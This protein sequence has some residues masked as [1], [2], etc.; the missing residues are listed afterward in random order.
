MLVWITKLLT[1]TE[2]ATFDTP[3]ETFQNLKVNHPELNFMGNKTFIIPK[4]H[5]VQDILGTE[6]VT[7]QYTKGKCFNPACE[8]PE[9]ME[10]PRDWPY[11]C[12]ECPYHC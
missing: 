3:N 5:S 10:G 6:D 12:V 2:L 8:S 1:G 9:Y 4:D 7:I 11:I